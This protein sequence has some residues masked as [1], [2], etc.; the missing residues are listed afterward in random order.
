MLG[1]AW[2]LQRQHFWREDMGKVDWDG[3]YQTYARLLPRLGS[4]S[5]L[6]DLMWEMQGELGTSHAYEY[7]GDYPGL[8]NHSLGLLG[9][10]FS[11]SKRGWRVDRVLPGM[12]WE[13]GR[14]SPL[15]RDLGSTLPRVIL[16][17]P[18]L[19]RSCRGVSRRVL[20]WFRWQAQR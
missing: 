20:H 2:W 3:V 4:R 11:W 9:A 15:T 17:C 16:S 8:P 10:D 14:A 13:P 19:V 7:G 18:L 12:P 6:S 5:E 1:E